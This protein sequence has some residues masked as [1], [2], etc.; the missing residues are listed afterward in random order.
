MEIP[1]PHPT[2]KNTQLARLIVRDIT[3]KYA[4]DFVNFQCLSEEKPEIQL[5][6]S[7]LQP[8]KVQ[9]VP[10][11]PLNLKPYP[12]RQKNSIALYDATVDGSKVDKMKELLQ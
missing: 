7:L 1:N 10:P 8:N 9:S 2:S 6:K 5:I 4:W 11:Q 3:G 12:A